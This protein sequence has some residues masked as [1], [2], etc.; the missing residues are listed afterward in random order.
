MISQYSADKGKLPPSLDAL[1]EAG[2][3]KELPID[4]MTDQ[5]DWEAEMGEDPNLTQGE[6]GVINVR[7]SSTE[8]SLD[9]KAYN[10]F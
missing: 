3:V 1:V 7:S 6:Q 10:E 2:Y 9:G 8:P 4:P 5:A